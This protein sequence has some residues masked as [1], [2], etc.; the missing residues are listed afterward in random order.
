MSGGEQNLEAG[1]KL[2][3]LTQ[4]ASNDPAIYINPDQVTAVRS[5]SKGTAIY[6]VGGSEAYSLHFI[7]REGLDSVVSL[8]AS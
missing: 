4:A 8:L 1:M 7:V 2:V 5:V 3:K 6:L